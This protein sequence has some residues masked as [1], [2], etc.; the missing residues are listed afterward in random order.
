[1]SHAPIYDIGLQAG[2]QPGPGNN[3]AANVNTYSLQNASA[4]GGSYEHTGGIYLA[5][6][7]AATFGTVTLQK[8]GP[9]GVTW[10][11]ILTFNANGAQTAY[12]PRGQYRWGVA[13]AT[14]VY[15]YSER[16]P[17]A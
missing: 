16:V 6:V 5:S 12:L 13:G 11:T 4:N 8:L 1:M 15:T 17:I 9:D 14:G 2:S 7:V 3:G 10:L